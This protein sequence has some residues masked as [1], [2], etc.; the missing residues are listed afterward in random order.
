[1]NTNEHK[2]TPLNSVDSQSHLL[3]LNNMQ[4]RNAE[5][6]LK[7]LQCARELLALNNVSSLATALLERLAS[8]A[9]TRDNETGNHLRRT[10]HYIRTLANCLREH[11]YYADQLDDRFV[12]LLYKSAPLHDL[13]KLGIPDHILL[14]P[15]RLEPHEFEVIK[16]HPCLGYQ[17]LMQ[18]E[19][20]LGVSASALSIA[21]E[22]ALCHHEKWDGSGYPQGLRGEAIPLSARLMAVAD[23]YDAIISRRVYKEATSHELAAKIIREGRGRHF[24]PIVVDAFFNLE[25]EFQDIAQRYAFSNVGVQ[26][27]F[28]I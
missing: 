24:D 19:A 2:N 17:A 5:L 4:M 27:Q 7:V 11:S 15:G 22:I 9:E 28:E 21:K 25:E 18:A 26:S 14:K 20:L 12:E 1:M 16:Q 6:D 3:R 10:Q 8:L 23:V 13:G